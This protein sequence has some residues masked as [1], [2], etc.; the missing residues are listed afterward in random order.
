MSYFLRLEGLP[1]VKIQFGDRA[2]AIK[3]C[4]HR[5]YIYASSYYFVED[6]EGMRIFPIKVLS[7]KRIAYGSVVCKVEEFGDDE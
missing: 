7:E 5:R 4:K 6:A 3:E 1:E 2:D